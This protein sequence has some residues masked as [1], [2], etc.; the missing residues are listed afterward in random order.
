VQ[1]VTSTGS[2]SYSDSPK[3]AGGATPD[4]PPIPYAN[5]ALVGRRIFDLTGFGSTNI[6][7]LE[8]RTKYRIHDSASASVYVSPD[9]G[10]T[11]SQSNLSS[12]AFGVDYSNPNWDGV[13]SGFNNDP[14]NSD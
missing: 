4:V 6:P 8:I 9:G 1:L 2:F 13:S 10:F 3:V 11:W 12:N 5:T 7:V 14:Y